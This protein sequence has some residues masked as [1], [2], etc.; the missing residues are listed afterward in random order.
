MEPILTLDA[1]FDEHSWL[2]EAKGC[3]AGAVAHFGRSEYS[4]MFY[5][6]TRLTQDIDEE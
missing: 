6:K 4:L 5:D 1:D 3:Y 2:Y